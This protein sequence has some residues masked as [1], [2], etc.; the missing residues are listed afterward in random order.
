MTT[1]DV[2]AA[3]RTLGLIEA[4]ST[5]RRP[6]S[7]TELASEIGAPK[8]SC[9]ELLQTLKAHGYQYALGRRQGFYPTRRLLD[10]ARVIA[11]N[12]PVLR[13]M[14]PTL[15]ALRD[16]TGE[17]V[18]LGQGQG[19][20]IVYLEVREGPHSIRY[21][22]R[23][24]DRKPLHSSAIGKA[25]L[26]EINDTNLDSM[27]ENLVLQQITPN[28]ITE[29]AHLRSEIV[30]GREMG[31]FVTRGEN[32]TDVSAVATIVHIHGEPFGVA[33]AGPSHR[34]D[35]VLNDIAQNLMMSKTIEETTP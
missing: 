5:H 16:A 22:A 28:T 15:S 13:R 31:Y 27:L 7:L 35:P 6:L 12:D 19:D 26:G 11:E 18:I 8:T 33:I 4:F 14:E 30:V 32:V 3:W 34:M 20:E 10:H 24:G 21:S 17:T 29:I 23:A 2:K 25:F 9:F 1:I